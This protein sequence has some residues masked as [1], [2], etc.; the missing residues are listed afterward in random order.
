[1]S[2][3]DKA[4]TERNAKTLRELI[5]RPENKVCADCKRNGAILYGYTNCQHEAWLT[6][7]LVA[8]AR[9]TMGIVEHVSERW[10]RAAQG[11]LC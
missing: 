7:F 4:I 9:P 3:Q 1:M 6:E 10:I 8:I 5:K 11:M 2:R